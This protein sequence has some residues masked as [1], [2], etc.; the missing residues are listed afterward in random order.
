M[1]YFTLSSCF[2]LLVVLFSPFVCPSLCQADSIS[3]SG[4]QFLQIPTGVRGAGMGGA[5][6]AVADDAT[7]SYWNSAG[8]SQLEHFQINLQHIAYLAG[9]NYEFIAGALPL[10]P[11]STLG[12]SAS[13]DYVSPFNSTNN[14]SAVPGSASD[15]AVD[16]GYGQTF[17]PN[18][19]LGMGAKFI[20][21]NLLTYSATGEALDGGIL[22]STDQRDFSLG[23][24]VQNIGQL[25]SFSQYSAQEY[26]PMTYRVGLAYRFQ[27]RNTPQLTLAFDW[28]KSIDSDPVYAGGGEFCFEMDRVSFAL[29]GGYSFDDSNQDLEGLSGASLGAG[30]KFQG[31]ELDYALIPF[32]TLGNT[33]RFSIT[34]ELIPE[35]KKQ[36]L[37][38][39]VSVHV[40]PSVADTKTGSIQQATIEL[41]PSARTEINNWTLEIT[42]PKGNILR[43]YAGKGVPPREIAWDGKDST[44]NVVA[45]GIFARYNLRT[46]DTKG[47]EVTARGALFEVSPLQ[48]NERERPNS[49]TEILTHVKPGIPPL[50]STVQPLGLSGVL[51]IPSI[52][53][54]EGRSVLQRSFEPYLDQVAQLIRKYPHARVYIE[55]HSDGEGNEE[56]SLRLSQYRA[57]AVMRFLVEGP[58]ISPANLY[59]RGRG[60]AGAIG[61]SGTEL[62]HQR[63]RRV[64]IIILT[65]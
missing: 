16:L 61:V 59:A 32:G 53:F 22:L 62:A 46:V 42:D 20:N 50:P 18:V 54:E 56:E 65:K 35:D 19:S 12:L 51:K 11:G 8:L 40:Q 23:L 41:K 31:W 29:R 36:P 39:P 6:T 3:T 13:Y 48:V 64:E 57:D 4:V 34:F 52:P 24:S 58:K 49:A 33:Q 44:E 27:P 43:T 45:G 10:K 17:S 2:L 25:S 5:F 21:S 26:L 9:T 38:S 7:A 37:P 63:N 47:Q 30:V 55:G 15:L 60:S 28:L 14:P 1:P